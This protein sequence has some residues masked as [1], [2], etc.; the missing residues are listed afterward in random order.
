MLGG[1]VR[2]AQSSRHACP[3]S[4]NAG[5]SEA[6]Q[7]RWDEPLLRVEP[8]T[9]EGRIREKNVRRRRGNLPA[10]ISMTSV[11]CVATLHPSLTRQR[12]ARC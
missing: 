4:R 6:A 7:P 12:T 8:K 2:L 10:A 9:A 1:D 5:K 11:K 3:H